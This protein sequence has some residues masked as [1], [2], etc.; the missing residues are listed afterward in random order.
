MLCVAGEKRE[1]AGLDI[2]GLA[3]GFGPID[4]RRQFRILTLVR[5]PLEE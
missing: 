3:N 4:W 2:D 5:G 1:P